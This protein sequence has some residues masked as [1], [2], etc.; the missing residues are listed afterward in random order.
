M[1]WCP[2]MAR[3][4]PKRE[5]AELFADECLLNAEEVA[6]LCRCKV[7]RVRKMEEQGE[8]PRAK[9]IGGMVRW[10][11]SHILK[12]IAEGCPPCAK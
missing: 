6:A 8:L 10:P 3:K 7:A 1:A 12:W 4:N 11:R 5:E 2:K 9:R